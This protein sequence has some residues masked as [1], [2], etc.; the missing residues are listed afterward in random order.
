MAASVSTSSSKLDPKN[1]VLISEDTYTNP[2]T[3]IPPSY[4][5]NI[6]TKKKRTASDIFTILCAGFAL[7][8]DGYQNNVMSILNLV[9]QKLYPETYTKSL[10][11]Q[12]SNSVLVGMVIGQIIV[13]LTCD[14]YGRKFAFVATTLFIVIGSILA[15]ASHGSTTLGMFWMI[16]V[17]RGI[18]GFGA[19]GEYPTSSASASEA[20]NESISSKHRGGVFIMVTNF[21]LS[22]GGPFALIIFLI[23]FSATGGVNV[24]LWRVM[25]GLGIIWPL[26]VFFFRLKMKTSKLYAKGAIRKQYVPYILTFKFYW[27]RLLGTCGAW[28]LYDVVAF[29]NGIFSATIISTALKTTDIKRVAEWTL[30]L[31]IISLPGVFIGAILVDKIGRKYTMMLGFTGYIIFG[32]I[33]GIAFNKIVK[34]VPLFIIFYG[35]FMSFGNMGPGDC[36]G[37]SASESYATAVRGTCYGL[38]AAIGKVG[39]VV[40]TY[41]FQ[42]V[43]DRLGKGWTFIICAI[44]GL[45]GVLIAYLCIP[46]LLDEDL[47][48]EDARFEKYLRE[49]GWEGR[50]GDEEVEKTTIEEID[51][52]V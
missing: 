6:S 38:S 28:F 29:A 35:V 36:L 5:L 32:L 48:A 37:L 46:H 30:L 43:L 22:L 24:T 18:I 39:S 40:G 1:G 50:F 19:G 16:I 10:K 25:F 49:N 31:N 26:S 3:N 11:T 14:Y 47:G 15:T 33:I 27:V 34:I 51:K 13:G 41:V 4:D 7:I 44:C 20:A 23:V 8:S 42:I 2:I 9:F 45:S 21:P 12:V 52:S 17:S